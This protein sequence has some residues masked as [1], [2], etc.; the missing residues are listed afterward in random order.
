[1]RVLMLQPNS[2]KT[3]WT[4]PASWSLSVTWM[5]RMMWSSLT[6]VPSVVVVVGPGAL[7]RSAQQ[8]TSRLPARTCASIFSVWARRTGSISATLRSMTCSPTARVSSLP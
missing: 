2:V 4:A 8:S 5:P 6:M 7:R 3:A 1:M